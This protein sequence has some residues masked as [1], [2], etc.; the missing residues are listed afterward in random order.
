MLYIALIILAFM[1]LPLQVKLCYKRLDKVY[2]PWHNLWFCPMIF[3]WRKPVTLVIC[4]GID[5]MRNGYTIL[6][7]FKRIPLCH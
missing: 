5:R 2:K 3:K 4:I 6:I 7:R 1:F